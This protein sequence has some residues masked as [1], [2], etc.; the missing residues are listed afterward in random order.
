MKSNIILNVVEPGD[1]APVPI[2]PGVNSVALN[3]GLFTHGIGSLETTIIV[4]STVVILP[5]LVFG[6]EHL[7]FSNNSVEPGTMFNSNKTIGHTVRCMTL[8]Q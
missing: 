2:D 8:A 5:I 1:P 3:T 7:Y 4:V 6:K